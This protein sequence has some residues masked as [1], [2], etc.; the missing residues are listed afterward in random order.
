MSVAGEGRQ[1]VDAFFAATSPARNR[2]YGFW[3]HMA[4]MW[5]FAKRRPGM[6]WPDAIRA[7]NGSGTAAQHYRQAVVDRAA[8]A[9]AAATAGRDFTPDRI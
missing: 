6:S 1:A 2:D 4:V 7:Y 9:R 8:A 3:I 5:L